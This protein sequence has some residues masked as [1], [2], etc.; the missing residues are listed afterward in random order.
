VQCHGTKSSDITLQY[1]NYPNCDYTYYVDWLLQISAN[2]KDQG[3]Q[4]K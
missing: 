4:E 2:Q 1:S 3:K